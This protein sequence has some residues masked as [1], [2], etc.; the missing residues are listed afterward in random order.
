MNSATTL[1]DVLAAR[2]VKPLTGKYKGRV[3]FVE[4]V[5]FGNSEK[6]VCDV[7]KF[8]DSRTSVITI[9]VSNVETA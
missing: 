1:E 6:V 2:Y 4:G 5:A 9:K 8:F 3:L 7:R